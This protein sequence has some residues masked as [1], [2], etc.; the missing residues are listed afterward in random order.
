MKFWV[1]VTD[2]QW[3]R[4]L[5]H[6]EGVDE[7]NF[8]HPSGRPPFTS[9]PEGT[10]F[11]FKLK[12]PYHHI[13]GGGFFVKYETLPLP[14]AWDAFGEKNGAASY[15]KLQALIG[16]LRSRDDGTT[17]EIGC[18]IL[19]SPFFWP[20]ADWISVGDDFAGNI[21]TGKTF[22]TA[23]TGA[24]ARLWQ[25]VERRLALYPGVAAVAEP[26]QL[27]AY[28]A[29]VPVRPR[30]GQGTFRA[31]VTNAYARRCAITGENTLPVLEAAHIKPFANEGLNNTYNGLLLRADFHK[32]FDRGL[33]TVTPD[34][35]VNVSKAIHEHWFNGKVYYRLHGEKLASLPASPHDQPRADFLA[36]HN[37]N[38]FEKVG[39]YAP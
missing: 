18:S 37:E 28:G 16:P 10:P 8:W 9:L 31:L 23:G 29:P 22:D 35:R 26:E 14:L 21:V 5:V 27:A 7:V 25:E 3:Y 4:F 38:V 34:Y 36:W 39:D 32:L 24:G 12:R 19:S 15:R 20:E 17:P 1:G 2:N 13:A 11:L 30:R 6:L 33:V